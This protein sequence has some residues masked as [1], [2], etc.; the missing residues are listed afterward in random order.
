MT[1]QGWLALPLFVLLSA[2]ASNAQC[3]MY[4]YQ[5]IW[6]DDSGNAVG[7]NYTHAACIGGSAHAFVQVRLPSGDQV[8]AS[9]TG[10]TSADAIA[11]SSGSE[12]G[13]GLLSG[14]NET[15]DACFT[16][17]YA[18]FSWPVDYELA[19][20]KSK[21][22]GFTQLVGEGDKKCFVDSWCTPA[23]T[24]PTCNPSW[25]IQN[26]LIPGL[27]AS[28]WQY[29]YTD[30][31]AVRIRIVDATWRCFPLILSQNA[32]GTIDSSLKACTK[33]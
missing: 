8:G 20:T 25:V 22:N 7:E 23:T 19:Y 10:S 31:V 14:S 2:A 16:A 21:W 1:K 27:E 24:P 4:T 32:R 17:T 6:L 3:G 9:A 26:P 11:Q 30:W 13:E 33:L 15:V 28:C 18:S 12:I 5:D 29:Y